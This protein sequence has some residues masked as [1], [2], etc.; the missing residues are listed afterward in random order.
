MKKGFLLLAVLGCCGGW[1]AAQEIHVTGQQVPAA[2][3]FAQ[4]Y[5]VRFELSHTPG[6]AVALDTEH[7]PKDFDLLQASS[8]T[9]SPGTAAYDLR[10]L[11]FTLGKSTFTAVT[12]TLQGPSGE[13]AL[14]QGTSRPQAVEIKPVQFFKEKTL[15]DIRPPYIPGNGWIWLL[16]V[17][18]LGL[19]V[20]FAWRFGRKLRTAPAAGLPGEPDTRPADEIALSKIQIL[21]QSGLWERAEYK[22]FYLELGDILREYF[23]RRFGLDVSANTSVEL[24]RRARKLPVMQPLLPALRGYLDEADLVKFAR[25]IPTETQM[26]A[27]VQTLQQLVRRTSPRPVELKEAPH[28]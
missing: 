2:A 27:Q 26:H 19:V 3:S 16:C 7:L 14:A 23:W 4:P 25:A 15:R 9:L 21:L 20:Y 18:I 28:D 17:L 13:K 22:L 24:L 12:F 1:L 5:D 10:F 11:P 8:Q 6:Y